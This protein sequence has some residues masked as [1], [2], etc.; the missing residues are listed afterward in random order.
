MDRQ[1]RDRI[2]GRNEKV[3]QWLL[4]YR[5]ARK[6]VRRLEEELRELV[7]IQRGISAIGYT[8]M[9]K[10]GSGQGDLS[11]FMVR[12]ENAVSKIREAQARRFDLLQEI[13]KVI[14]SLPAADERDIITMRYISGKPWHAICNICG[15]EWAQV[16]RIHLKALAEIYDSIKDA[17]E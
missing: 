9:P 6:D 8:D 5:E 10:G 11:E 12:Q 14:N 13:E 17:I 1:E 16:H 7:E 4:R 2:R 3:K 15:Y